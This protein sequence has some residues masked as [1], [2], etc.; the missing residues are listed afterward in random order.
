[1]GYYLESLGFF[2]DLI[3][4]K[5]FEFW[6]INCF[7]LVLE[8]LFLKRVYWIIFTMFK[9]CFFMFWGFW[10]IMLVIFVRRKISIKKFS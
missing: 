6:F 7:F 9:V 5:F 10:K 2:F 4:E 8:F 3:F 1:M